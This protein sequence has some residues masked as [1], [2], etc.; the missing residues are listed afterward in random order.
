MEEMMRP[1]AVV[2]DS[3]FSPEH[4][5][6]DL[7]RRVAAEIESTGKISDKLKGEMVAANARF[8]EVWAVVEIIAEK[9]L[10]D[11]AA[12]VSVENK[13]APT[14]PDCGIKFLRE[15][16]QVSIGILEHRIKKLV[17]DIGVLPYEKAAVLSVEVL[18]RL[19]RAEAA[20]ERSLN[21]AIDRLERLQRRR[22]GEAVPP[23]V[24]VRLT[25]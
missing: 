24:S 16:I 2:S 5:T 23:P 6:L 21:R 20:A 13:L 9:R 22:M 1:R 12:E 14:D 7:L 8:H 18:D 15:G 19:L 3:P 17:E 11:C 4:V 10:A 25:R